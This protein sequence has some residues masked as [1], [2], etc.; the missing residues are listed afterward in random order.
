MAFDFLQTTLVEKE[1][2]WF[3][4]S[5]FT[6]YLNAPVWLFDKFQQEENPYAALTLY[7]EPLLKQV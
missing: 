4:F 6:F 2:N 7:W 3:V 5:S 1:M